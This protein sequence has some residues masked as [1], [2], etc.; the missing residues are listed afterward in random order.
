MARGDGGK[1]IFLGK[2]DCE[3]FLHGLERV[4]QSHGWRVHAWVLM[5]NPIRRGTTPE[6]QPLDRVLDAFR[7]NHERRGRVAYV[8]WLET[9]AATDGGM[10]GEKAMEAIRGGWYLVTLRNNHGESGVLD[11]DLI[12][13]FSSRV[14]L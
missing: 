13:G 11:F 1:R 7:L 12:S 4:R 2:E 14:P 9:R 10:I 8:S 5:G 6:W 3:S